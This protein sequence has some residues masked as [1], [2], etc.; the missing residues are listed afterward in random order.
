VRGLGGTRPVLEV[1]GEDTDVLVGS[2]EGSGS[3][4]TRE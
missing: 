2:G 4:G 1:L 3:V